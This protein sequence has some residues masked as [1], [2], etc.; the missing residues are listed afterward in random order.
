MTLPEFIQLGPVLK[1]PYQQDPLL[2]RFLKLKLPAAMMSEITPHLDRLGK[3]AANEMLT[4]GWDA[5]LHPPRLVHYDPWGTRIDEI[6]L[7]CG[8]T[9]LERLASTEGVV[10]TAYE[11]KFGALSR[12][13]QMSLL[14]LYHPSSS[15]ASCPLAMTD[16]AA[17][18]IELYGDEELKQK[19]LKNL[20]SRNPDQSWTS[21]QWM[22]ERSGGSDVGDS[23]TIAKKVT[24]KGVTHYELY[25]VKWFTSATNSQMAMTL[26]RIEGAEAG[27]R[28][29][30]LFYLETKNAQ[31]RLNNIEIL[32]LKDKMGTKALPTAELRLKGTPAKLVGGEGGGV[33]K[34]SSLFNITRMY[35][36]TSSIGQMRRGVDLAIDYAHKRRA[37]GKLLIDHPLHQVTL[38]DMEM[39][40][41]GCFHLVMKAV[42]LLGKEEVGEASEKESSLLRV[43]TPLAKL[44][45]GKQSVAVCSEAVECF[46]GA[47]YIEDTGIPRLLRDAQVLSIWEGTTNVLSLDML[48]AFDKDNGLTAISEDLKIRIGKLKSTEAQ[49][50]LSSQ[51]QKW[52]TLFQ[53]HMQN[54]DALQAFARRLSMSLSEIYL[55]TLT[56]EFAD[57]SQSQWD[58]EVARWWLA[59][60]QTPA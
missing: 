17:R 5:E 11:R 10:A 3:Y 24:E 14:Y 13:L 15:I 29:L 47:G 54:Q 8:W 36:A 9:N 35:N 39:T 51:V 23:E 38:H 44:Y 37:F 30:S 46:G 4:W 56:C 20:I 49:K 26:A 27:S 21:G 19:A 2:A 50:I 58:A 45:T 60:F 1:N 57:L 53:T 31:G 28:G 34:I 12:Y 18:A 6:Q 7:S 43:L 16:G 32:R 55:T 33:K 52:S 48:R 42:E 41:A 25:G 40:W 22:T 59:K